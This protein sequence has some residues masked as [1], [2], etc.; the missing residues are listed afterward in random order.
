MRRLR[1][2]GRPLTLNPTLLNGICRAA[3]DEILPQVEICRRFDILYQTY[4]HWL[5]TG[6]A[7]K[8]KSEIELTPRQKLCV[9]LST[10]LERIYSEHEQRL[11]ES[12]QSR[13]NEVIA[14]LV[15][16]FKPDYAFVESI[17]QGTVI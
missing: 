13:D 6:K 17:T 1:P 11:Q 8:N 7:C 12:L 15:M 10:R 9:E 5:S 14:R 3:S 2:V 4:S 16:C